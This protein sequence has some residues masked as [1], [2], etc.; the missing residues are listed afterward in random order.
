MGIFEC[1]R[2]VGMGHESLM[3]LGPLA[4]L[5]LTSCALLIIVDKISDS[6]DGCEYIRSTNICLPSMA[7]A[8]PL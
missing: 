7:K 1:S 8:P 3:G 4:G 2:D 6:L 5:W